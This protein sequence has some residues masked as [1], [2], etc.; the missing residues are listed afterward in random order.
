MKRSV[1]TAVG[2]AVIAMLG[3]S[4]A[5]QAALINFTVTAID[6]TP[7]YTGPSAGPVDRSRRRYLDTAGFRGRPF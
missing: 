7:G 3:A 1:I 5:A 2:A 6:G 4:S